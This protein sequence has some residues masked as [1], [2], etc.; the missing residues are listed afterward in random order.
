M[1]LYLFPYGFNRCMRAKEA[2]GQRLV[3]AQQTQQQVLRLDVRRPELACFIPREEDDA[4]CFFRIAFEHVP[5]GKVPARPTI[6]AV[7]AGY[8]GPPEPSSVSPLP[9]AEDPK[10]KVVSILP[11]IRL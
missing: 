1:S 5:P 6:P 8:P 9:R 4:T 11:W 3:F 10:P 2:I 7:P